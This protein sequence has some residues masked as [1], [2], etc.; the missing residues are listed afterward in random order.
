[1][2]ELR[3]VG[4][5]HVSQKS[6]DEVRAAVLEFSPDVIAIELDQGRYIALKRQ[7][8]DPTVGQ[9]L[10]AKNFTQ[11]LVQWTLAYL[12]RKIG[13]DV[14][15]EPGAEMKAAIEEAE[16]R[17][18]RLALIDRDIR[19]TLRRFWR[20]LSII[21]KLK[22]FYALAV[23]ITSIDGGD[24]PIDELTKQD[25]VTLALEEF[26]KFSPRGAVALID[27]RD[28][29]LA[30]QICGLTAGNDR[31]LAVMGAGH[32]QGVT[33]FL[34]APHTLP[35]IEDL[36]ADIKS[37]PWG[38]IFGVA[39]TV[40]FTL[41]LVAIAF[42]G[43]GLDVLLWALLYWVLIHGVLTAVFT[44]AAGGHPLSALTGFAVSWFT[45]LNPLIAAGWFSAIVEAKIR[46]PG[47]GDFRKILEAGSFR[48]MW[49][50]PLFKVVLVAAL[51]N[52][53]STLG[54]F[55]YFVFIFPILGIDPTALVTQG[56]ANMWTMAV[57]LF[58]H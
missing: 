8:E 47:V 42:S 22:L 49:R 50:I 24:I 18:I 20:S 28:A 38:L 26:R 21:E 45:A 43:V 56:F 13:M 37:P 54:T 57:G 46:K 34:S 15:V 4:T 14:G 17:Q 30:H 29:F 6:V 7:S 32:V 10:E 41:L 23:S 25:V 35:P 3:I 52:V 2:G 27:E 16:N 39:V 12:Q 53:G 9:V 19:I 40:V 33:K 31:V 5:A 36:S 55:A 51:A 1:M 44:L 48:E 11:L 58:P